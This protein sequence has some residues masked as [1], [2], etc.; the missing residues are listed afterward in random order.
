MIDIQMQ[1]ESSTRRNIDCRTPE[2]ERLNDS[3][4]VPYDEELPF[5]F[6]GETV[7]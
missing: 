7:S 6:T 1:I 3:E 4:A 2:T 5:C